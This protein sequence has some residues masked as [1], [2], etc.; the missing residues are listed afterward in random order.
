MKQARAALDEGYLVC[1]FAEGQ[2]TRNGML[3]EFRGG[4]ER[5]V[6]GTTYPII[7]V[8]IGGAW[9]STLSYAN[10]KLLSRLPTLS[11][12]RVSILFG[13]PM[14]STS[15]ATEVRQKVAELSC[16]YF[17]SSKKSRR[18]LEP[19]IGLPVLGTGKMDLKEIREIALAEAPK[20]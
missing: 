2:L 16:D 13:T 17:D 12:Y 14:A 9:G 11:P 6:K 10:G 8:Y 7:P 1:I 15:A 20:S 19:T 4:F 5:I 18:P 3:R